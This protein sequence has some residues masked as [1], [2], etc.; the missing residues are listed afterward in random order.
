MLFFSF[1]LIVSHQGDRGAIMLLQG[2]LLGRRHLPIL[3]GGGHGSIEQPLP[4]VILLAEGRLIEGRLGVH[5]AGSCSRT[6][7]PARGRLI[8]TAAWNGRL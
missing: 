8:I 4:E 3:E 7:L 1:S 5:A 2:L 6:G